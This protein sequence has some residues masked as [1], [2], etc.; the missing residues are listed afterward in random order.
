MTTDKTDD[1]R[2]NPGSLIILLG[3]IIFWGVDWLGAAFEAPAQAILLGQW[4][5]VALTGFGLLVSLPG[6]IFKDVPALVKWIRCGG[7]SRAPQNIARATRAIVMFLQGAPRAI[8][9][10]AKCLWDVWGPI[11]SCP[12]QS[13]LSRGLLDHEGV[14]LSLA[15]SSG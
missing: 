4:I 12:S 9:A 2:P 3:C 1:T 7:L 13:V 8:A 5:G 10:F 15:S 6:F 14:C 11:T